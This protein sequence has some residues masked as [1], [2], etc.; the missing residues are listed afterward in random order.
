[1]MT[2][3]FESIQFTSKYEKFIPLGSNVSPTNSPRFTYVLPSTTAI[4]FSDE[5]TPISNLFAGLKLGAYKSVD[6][7]NDNRWF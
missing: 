3:G 1:M 7:S 5:T 6:N 4:R 2:Q